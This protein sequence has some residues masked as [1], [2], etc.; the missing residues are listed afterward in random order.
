MMDLSR[1]EEEGGENIG[2]AGSSGAGLGGLDAM[3]RQGQLGAKWGGM[4][5]EGL[6]V[7]DL[8]VKF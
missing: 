6:R 4:V 8:Q 1:R 2:G 3:L 5:W 7:N